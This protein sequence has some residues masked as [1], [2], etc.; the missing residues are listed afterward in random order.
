MQNVDICI[1]VREE[2]TEMSDSRLTL[3]S[4]VPGNN[5]REIQTNES[6]SSGDHGGIIISIPDEDASEKT[7]TAKTISLDVVSSQD[8]NLPDA[9]SKKKG[10]VRCESYGE[11]CR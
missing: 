1:H 11:E 5:G 9:S 10:F 7:V 4:V 3:N 2:E 8:D 6:M